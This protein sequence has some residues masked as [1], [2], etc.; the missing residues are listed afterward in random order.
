MQNLFKKNGSPRLTTWRYKSILVGATHVDIWSGD[1][2][3]RLQVGIGTT[4]HP[5]SG[6]TDG[7]RRGK[8]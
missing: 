6:T 8:L 3:S 5:Q 1:I 7:L 2:P 4:G